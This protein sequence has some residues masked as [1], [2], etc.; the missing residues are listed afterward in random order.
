MVSKTSAPAEKKFDPNIKKHIKT[1]DGSKDEY[2]VEI[3]KDYDGTV[4]LFYLNKKD[5]KYQYRFLRAEDKNLS[6]KTSGLLTD[7]GGWQ[8]VQRDHLIRMGI[9]ETEMIDGLYRV[10]DL[11]LAF[12]PKE[13]Y[14]KK[15]KFKNEKANAPMN[16][17]NRMMEEGTTD[18]EI[19]SM[20]EKMTGLRTEK[21]LG[22]SFK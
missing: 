22:V 1:E 17:V 4:D 18:P 13:L 14:E 5:P 19:A 16:A 11:V 7:L 20:G 15:E 12:M 21:D 10:G 2:N 8:L 3:I 6:R 9:K